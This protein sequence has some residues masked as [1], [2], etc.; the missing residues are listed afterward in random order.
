MLIRSGHIRASEPQ[1]PVQCRAAMATSVASFVSSKTQ[2]VPD[3]AFVSTV[4]AST[5]ARTFIIAHFCQPI[6]PCSAISWMWFVRA[7]ERSRLTRSASRSTRRNDHGRIWMTSATPHTL[8]PDHRHRRGER[9]DW[10]ANTGRA[11]AVHAASIDVFFRQFDRDNFTTS[12]SMPICNF[13]RTATRLPCFFN[14]HSPRR[15]F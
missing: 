11:V 2:R 12:G 8:C 1:H 6:R 15:Q 9:C 14:Q 7:S 4:A 3:H 10:I 5:F 13:A